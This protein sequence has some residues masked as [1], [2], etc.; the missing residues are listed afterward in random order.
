MGW[1]SLQAQG[2]LPHEVSAFIEQRTL[3]EHFR[4]EPW[5]EGN[6]SAEQQ[7]REFLILQMEHYCT[8]SDAQ[9]GE[10]RQRYG[11]NPEVLQRLKDFETP[12][13]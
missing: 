13:E 6:S 9:L 7:R 8:G 11:D 1:H 12:L 10:L 4:Q 2:A 5:P 3:C